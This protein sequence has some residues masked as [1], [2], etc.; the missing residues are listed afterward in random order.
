MLRITSKVRIRTIIVPRY[1]RFLRQAKTPAHIGKQ[2]NGI[3]PLGIRR[4]PQVPPLAQGRFVRSSRCNSCSNEIVRLAGSV[5]KV[6]G[7]V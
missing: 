6:E 3:A 7:L 5:D 4:A 2:P 1:R